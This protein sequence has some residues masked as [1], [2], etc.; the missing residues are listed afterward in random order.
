MPATILTDMHNRFYAAFR[1]LDLASLICD[2]ER[3]AR[4]RTTVLQLHREVMVAKDGPWWLTVDRLIDDKRSSVTDAE[5][6]QLIADLEE[7]VLHFS[8]SSKAEFNPHATRD[9]AKV[10][11]RHYNRLQR[12]DDVKRLHTIVAK[13]FEHFA[14]LGDA[15]VAPAVLQTAVDAYHRAGLPEE[16]KRVRIMMQEKIG[17]GRDQM[18]PIKTEI[19]IP[20]EDMEKFLESIIVDD[21]WSTFTRIGA[22]FL[23]KRRELEEQ[24]RKTVVAAPL[25]AHMPI[26]ITADDH[27]AAK[28]GSVEDDPFGWLLHQT[29]MNF[30]FEGIWLHVALERAISAHDA[31]PEHFAAWANRAALFEDMSF[32][33]EGI[34][35]W[36]EGD[37]VKATHVLVP[38][39]E[40]GLRSIV[41]KLG[42]PVTKTHATVPGVGV[43]IGMGDILYSEQLRDVLG[44][45]LTLYFLAL[46]ADPRGMN[47]RN[48]VAHGLIKAERLD[49]QLVR[50]LIHTLL[51][52]GIWN[53]LSQSGR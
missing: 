50:L 15:L 30:G 26:T 25:L 38:Q 42:K 20:R 36:Y 10:L 12:F 7:L 19:K 23:P 41:A 21:L 52:F 49:G 17:Q 13:V 2:P 29:K 27:I 22:Q 46:Y 28:L 48:R 31:T 9:A 37:F 43:A 8:D 11:I 18:A 1:A 16:N 6:Q 53:E 24:V 3:I 51:V 44:P 47:L 5:R 45:D 40:L 4:S 39:M 34:R 32:L 35:A 33:I 14:G